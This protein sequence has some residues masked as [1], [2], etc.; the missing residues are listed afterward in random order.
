MLRDDFSRDENSLTEKADPIFCARRRNARA[1]ERCDFGDEFRHVGGGAFY[2]RPR[3][4]PQRAM[5]GFKVV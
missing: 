5:P 4:T 2:L 1:E 3:A